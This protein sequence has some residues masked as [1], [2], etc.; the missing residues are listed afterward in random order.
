ME[1]IIYIILAA[2]ILVAGYFIYL[3]KTVKR[4][5]EKL[6]WHKSQTYTTLRIDVPKN[7]EK[8]PLSAEQM[9]ASIHGIYSESSR[10]QNHLSFEIVAIDKYIQFYVHLPK[11]I[12]D[13]VE[14]QIYA[15]YPTVEITEVPDYATKVRPK[16]INFASCELTLT[17]PDVY[18]IK[19]FST[20][21]VDPLSGIT[22]VLSD[23]GPNDEV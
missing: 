20:L 1:Y 16:D 17:K 15:Q 4:A 11:H 22:S 5:K 21:E 12:K 6:D 18:P 3:N 10:Y 14:G 23:L 8:T 7:N 9:F 13:F 2:L 19:T